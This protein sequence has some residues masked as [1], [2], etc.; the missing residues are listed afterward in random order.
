MMRFRMKPGAWVPFTVA[1][2]AALLLP[3][4]GLTQRDVWGTALETYAYGLFLDRYPLFVFALIYG[5]ARILAAA[6]ASG[7]TLAW[8]IPTALA[9]VALLLGAGLYPTFGGIVL[10]SGFFTGGM[11]FLNGMT[12][13]L[14]YLIG[15]AVAAATFGAVLSAAVVLIRRRISLAWRSLAAAAVRFLALWFAAFVLALPRVQGLDVGPWPAWPATLAQGG[16]MAALVA[17]ALAPHALADAFA[18]RVA[19]EPRCV[20]AG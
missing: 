16:A 1:V 20:P 9:G 2:G 4:S 5:A 6:A 11:A 17:V 13:P 14:S 10:R 12:A 18:H 8:H 19:S 3:L 7:R 15:T